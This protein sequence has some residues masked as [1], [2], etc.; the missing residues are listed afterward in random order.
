MI[1]SSRFLVDNTLQDL[2]TSIIISQKMK[3]IITISLAFTLMSCMQ[4]NQNEQV[5]QDQIKG[6]EAIIE[7]MYKPGFG[8]FMGSIQNHH[9]KLWFAGT[10]ENWELAE[11]EIH[12][13]EEIFEDIQTTHPDREETQLLSMIEPGLNEVDEAIDNKD[14]AAFKNAYQNLTNVCN[15]CHRATKHEFV[16]IVIPTAPSYTNQDYK[17]FSDDSI[18]P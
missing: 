1:F 6:Y 14:V 2:K 8:D 18:E 9:N 15:T 3:R 16:R 17:P 7:T 12:E 11:F 10:S 13:I 5:L 4:S